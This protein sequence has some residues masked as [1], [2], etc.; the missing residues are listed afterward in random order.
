M[1]H[2]KIIRSNQL[3]CK[4]TVLGHAGFADAGEDIVCAAVS[5]LTIS[6]LNGLTEIVGRKDLNEKID[7]GAVSFTIPETDN[8][9]LTRET[10]LLLDTFILGIKGVEE[11]YGSYLRIEEI[12]N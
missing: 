11:V 1:T 8:E 5:V 4:I 7:E 12:D 9:I 6:I 10:Q 3:I 2:I